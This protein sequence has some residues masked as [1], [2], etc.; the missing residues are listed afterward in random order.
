MLRKACI[1]TGIMKIMALM[2]HAKIC[3]LETYDLTYKDLWS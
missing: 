1:Q 2:D 3:K